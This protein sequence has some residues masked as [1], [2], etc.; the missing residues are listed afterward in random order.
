L[1]GWDRFIDDLCTID[2]GHETP[3]IIDRGA[4]EYLRS[5]IDSGGRVDLADFASLAH[6]WLNAECGDCDGADLTCDENVNL[7]DLNELAKYWMAGS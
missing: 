5:D 1:N 3:P 2:G 6:H 4:Y 7:D